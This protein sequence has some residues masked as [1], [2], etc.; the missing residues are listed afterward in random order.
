MMSN[1][2]A[3]STLKTSDFAEI[4]KEN[5]KNHKILLDKKQKASHDSFICIDLDL[6]YQGVACDL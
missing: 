1:R 3:E 4:L 6:F 5:H 2:E